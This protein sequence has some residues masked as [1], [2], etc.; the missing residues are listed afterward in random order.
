[1]FVGTITAVLI[2]NLIVGSSFYR[3][4]TPGGMPMLVSHLSFF[5]MLTEE[6]CNEPPDGVASLQAGPGC[7]ACLAARNAR[8]E[9]VLRYRR[10]QRR[11]HRH[12][13]Q[14]VS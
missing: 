13:D 2:Q 12:A 1:M 3:I 7:R 6:C 8:W 5:A 4:R 14:L 9:G 10:P 11:N